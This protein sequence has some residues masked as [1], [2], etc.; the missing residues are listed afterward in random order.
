MSWRTPTRLLRNL[1]LLST[2]SD[3]L[4]RRTTLWE[5]PPSTQPLSILRWAASHVL[6][7]L[8]H[9]PRG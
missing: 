8:K 7:C 6:N 1:T 2:Y 9:L 3:C 4:P 5:G